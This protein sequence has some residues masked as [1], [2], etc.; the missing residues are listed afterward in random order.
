MQNIQ[1]TKGTYHQYFTNCKEKD[2]QRILYGALRAN[3]IQV[4]SRHVKRS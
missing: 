2:N 1:I 4:A 3:I